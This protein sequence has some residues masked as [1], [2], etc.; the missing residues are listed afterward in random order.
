MRWVIVVLAV[1]AVLALGAVAIE[2]GRSAALRRRFGPE[3][4]RTVDERGDRR[5]AEA[6]LRERIRRRRRVELRELA[7]NVRER[8]VARWRS[9]QVGFVDEPRRS[10][11]EA[12]ALVGQVMGERGYPADGDVGDVGDVG[13]AGDPVELVAVDHPDLAEG[14]RVA[15]ATLLRSGET[16]GRATIDDL[17]DAFIRL[18]GLFDALVADGG[19]RV[20]DR[21]IRR[22]VGVLSGAER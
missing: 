8:H 4:R 21:G 6:A 1:V 9:I 3:Y 15:H 18:R 10:V 20:G 5:A 19:E 17:R 12:E 7:P 16:E 11:A 13:D 14:Y 22:R 2:L